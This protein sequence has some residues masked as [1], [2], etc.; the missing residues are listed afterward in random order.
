MWWTFLLLGCG[1]SGDPAPAPLGFAGVQ[2]LS[3]ERGGTLV[4]T[5]PA[6]EQ[7]VDGYELV[8]ADDAGERARVSTK[9]DA[10]SYRLVVGTDV[11]DVQVWVEAVAGEQHDAGDGPLALRLGQER[12]QLV[13]QVPLAGLGDVH[14]E[15][16]LVVT[17]GRTSGSSFFVYDVSEPEAPVLLSEVV[18]EGFVKDV[19][20]H[21][22]WLYTQG[23]C[24]DCSGDPDK[25]GDYDGIGV[26]VFDLS[27]PNEPRRVGSLQGSTL[28]E[29]HFSVHNV[30]WSDGF[31][32]LSDN[33]LDA[34]P[35]V[36]VREPSS[37]VEV[38]RYTPPE[39]I[40]HDQAVV[41]DRAYVAFWRGFAVLDVADPAQP[42]VLAEHTEPA[43][44]SVHTA[45]PTEDGQ[46]LL[47]S[48]ELPGGALTVFSLDDLGAIEL[49]TT[50]DPFPTD[51]IHNIVVQGS[52]AFVSWYRQGLVVV[53]LIDPEHPEV[54]A[55]FD[56]HRYEI[57]GHEPEQ[58]WALYAGAW[59]VWPRDDG[60]VAV[61]D[62]ENGL[63]LFR[64]HPVRV[65]RP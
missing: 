35:I 59:G 25:Q 1:G 52:Y 57:E 58:T 65:E 42:V 24:E 54:L 11:A 53:D 62:M 64:F 60:L 55:H 34:M 19:K 41:G 10:R 17:A 61:S 30:T 36:D 23:E 47:V 39:G 33:G 20:L 50:L 63:F 29:P 2:A 51:T 13:G 5:W 26:R 18:G 4:A 49:V 22:G 6:A 56:T 3:L 43:L 38:A 37:P 28:G 14:G 16:D 9:A 21:E 27:V 44:G 46:H 48:S 8:V 15:G 31:L 40:V 7:P 12:L 32:Y 45:W